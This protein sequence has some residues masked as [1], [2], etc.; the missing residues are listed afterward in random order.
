MKLERNPREPKRA[1]L[2]NPVQVHKVVASEQGSEIEGS[3]VGGEKVIETKKSDAGKEVLDIGAAETSGSVRTWER[4]C[5]C[6]LRV[7]FQYLGKGRRHVKKDL[8]FS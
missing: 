4:T 2:E 5:V 1:I 6:S 7:K 8:C 3:I